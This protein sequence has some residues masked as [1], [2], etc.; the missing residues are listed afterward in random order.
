MRRVPLIVGLALVA[1]LSGGAQTGVPGSGEWQSFSGTFTA[2]GRRDTVPRRTA[3]SPT[4]ARLT[5][6][7]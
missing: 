1:S 6:S 7:L 5:G 4:V 2:T 3:A